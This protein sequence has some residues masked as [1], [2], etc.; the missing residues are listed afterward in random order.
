MP[1]ELLRI[2][3]FMHLVVARPLA[4]LVYG[5]WLGMVCLASTTIWVRKRLRQSAKAE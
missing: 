4:W 2:E 3:R 5:C 1:A